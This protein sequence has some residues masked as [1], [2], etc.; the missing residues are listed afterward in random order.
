MTS[1]A[2]S[3][4]EEYFGIKYTLP[5]IDIVAV[6][7]FGFNAMENWG[8]VTFREASILVPTVNNKSSSIFHM[9]KVAVN[10]A[11]EI[12]HQWY[13]N[14]VT[15]KYFDDLWL[16]EGFATYLSYVAVDNV[17][18]FQSFLFLLPSIGVGRNYTKFKI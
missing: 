8:M 5:K 12:A 6:P 14:L 18:K 10:L 4:F 9:A 15:M 1:A 11:H 2:L 17:R 3:F 16:K 7:D 13:G